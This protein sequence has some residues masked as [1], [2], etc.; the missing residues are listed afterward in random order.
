MTCKQCGKSFPKRTGSYCG[1][2]VPTVTL[3]DNQGRTRHMNANT[4]LAELVKLGVDA[5]TIRPVPDPLPDGWWRVEGD[6]R[7]EHKQ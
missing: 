4:T 7:Q 2:C 5:I 6:S 1:G 3:R